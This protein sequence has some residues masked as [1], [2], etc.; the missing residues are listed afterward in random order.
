[1]AVKACLR[2]KWPIGR[3]H[4]FYLSANMQNATLGDQGAHKTTLALR[5]K[6]APVKQ[7]LVEPKVEGSTT[8]VEV[9]TLA[10]SHFGLAEGAATGGTKTYQLSFDDVVQSNLNATLDSLPLHGR[11]VELL[12]IEQFI[13]G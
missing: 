12:L 4:V 2:P 10:L 11:E 6:Y 1:L 9:K 3:T 7:P 8:L 13:Q 5:V